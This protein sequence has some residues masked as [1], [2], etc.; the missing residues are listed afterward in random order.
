MF[1]PQLSLFVMKH[2]VTNWQ[3]SSRSEILTFVQCCCVKTVL[4]KFI[5]IYVYCCVNRYHVTTTSL[6][7][8]HT[9]AQIVQL[10]VTG[11]YTLAA[12][13]VIRLSIHFWASTLLYNY[14]DILRPEGS[15]T[16]KSGFNVQSWV[17]S[18]MAFVTTILQDPVECVLCGVYV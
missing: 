8:E 17:A 14:M 6:T 10:L 5:C 2:F 9:S 7:W 12:A 4:S 3:L 13:N 15:L 16:A 1:R 18:Q 11:F